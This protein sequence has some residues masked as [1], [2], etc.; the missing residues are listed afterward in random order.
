[1]LPLLGLCASSIV[2]N[3]LPCIEPVAVMLEYKFGL[4]HSNSYGAEPDIS[5]SLGILKAKP[6]IE[7][8]EGTVAG[9]VNELLNVVLPSDAILNLSAPLL[10]KLWFPFSTF[11]N[12][13][14]LPITPNLKPFEVPVP[15]VEFCN[16]SLAIDDELATPKPVPL[17]KG[18]TIVPINTFPDSARD[19]I[20]SEY[21]RGS[22]GQSPKTVKLINEGK[23]AEAA[24]EFLNNEE[25]KN[26]NDL[27]KPGI[28]PRMERVATELNKMA[29]GLG[30]KS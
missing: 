11:S 14:L 6:P 27:G 21:Y 20:F 3:C 5:A 7:P 28:K 18:D 10:K 29:D 17:G 26:A 30:S 23:Y 19:A 22:I 2:K 16:I 25:Y 13:T 15:V 24:R 8:E 12:S 4:N 1:M 9:R